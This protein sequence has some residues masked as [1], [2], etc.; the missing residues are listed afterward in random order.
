MSEYRAGTIHIYIPVDKNGTPYNKN[1]LKV[2]P[3]PKHLFFL[4]DKITNYSSTVQ[5][6]DGSYLITYFQYKPEHEFTADLQ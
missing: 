1:T 2:Y 6:S 5:R 4:G 3:Q